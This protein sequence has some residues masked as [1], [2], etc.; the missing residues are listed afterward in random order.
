MGVP[1]VAKFLTIVVDQFKKKI[2]QQ[3]AMR[4]IVPLQK[5]A[6]FQPNEKCPPLTYKSPSYLYP[7]PF[8]SG[9]KNRRTPHETG[10]VKTT[11]QDH[12]NRHVP[13][14]TSPVTTYSR[15]DTVL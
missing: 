14:F 8:N 5:M 1:F 11:Q 6:S 10:S 2:M 4:R 13:V 12:Q 15:R 3:P 9:I 7:E